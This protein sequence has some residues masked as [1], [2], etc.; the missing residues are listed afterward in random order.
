M[1]KKLFLSISIFLSQLVFSTTV[2]S[3]TAPDILSSID[4]SGLERLHTDMFSRSSVSE[5]S[6]GS[7][8]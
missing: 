6:Y 7:N 5:D 2:F 8:A 3:Q 1:S 4:Y